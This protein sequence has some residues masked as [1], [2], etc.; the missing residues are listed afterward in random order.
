VNGFFAY[1]GGLVVGSDA[2]WWIPLLTGR[3]NTMPPINYATETS[4]VPDYW[5]RVNGIV[6]RLQDSPL[7]DPATLQFLEKNGISHVY[8]GEKGGPLLKVEELQQSS[9]YQ[10]V[11]QQDQVWIFEIKTRQ[12]QASDD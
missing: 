9:L 10:E 3:D 11:Y 12:E 8:I 1:G 6:Q 2:G 4:S 5:S 7:D